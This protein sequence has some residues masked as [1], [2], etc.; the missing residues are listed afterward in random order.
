MKNDLVI[1]LLASK[2]HFEKAKTLEKEKRFAEAVISYCQAIHPLI[3]SIIEDPMTQAERKQSANI[4]LYYKIHFDHLRDC[5]DMNICPEDQAPTSRLLDYYETGI[6]ARM[7]HDIVVKAL[8]NS[9]Q[10][11]KIAIE[12][13]NRELSFVYNET[14]WAY[15][16]ALSKIATKD[17]KKPNDV[18]AK[19]KKKPTKSEVIAEIKRK[20]NTS[21]VIRKNK[22][23]SEEKE[24]SAEVKI[25][26]KCEKNPSDVIK[27]ETKVESKK[28]GLDD[29]SD[30]RFADDTVIN[31][32]ENFDFEK[33]K[34]EI[35]LKYKQKQLSSE[36]RKCRLVIKNL[37]KIMKEEGR[38]IIERRSL[39][40]ELE[41]FSKKL[42]S[43]SADFDL[44]IESKLKLGSPTQERVEGKKQRRKRRSR[45]R[46]ESEGAQ[47]DDTLRNLSN[48]A[49]ET[50][51]SGKMEKEQFKFSSKCLHGISSKPVDQL[52]SLASSEKGLQYIDEFVTQLA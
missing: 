19:G 44:L 32:P 33:V 6:D 41:L 3:R 28:S 31:L 11:S 37:N 24:K 5:M 14:S 40:A 42:K 15:L 51:K 35:N 9:M 25:N 38:N 47:V 22:I 1:K 4:C 36:I 26:T 48:E 50:S 46:K 34:E 2:L 52:L 12:A 17:E 8:K 29:I 23:G 7:T 27:V 13:G 21:D 49:R 30:V 18:T 20:Q 39:K 16:V 10:K 45:E 43:L